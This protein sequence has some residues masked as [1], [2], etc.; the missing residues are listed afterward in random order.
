MKT[1]IHMAFLTE[2]GIHKVKRKTKS[3]NGT[4]SKYDT[5]RRV[6]RWTAGVAKWI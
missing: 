6:R 1:I 4:G 2:S 3:M 5:H